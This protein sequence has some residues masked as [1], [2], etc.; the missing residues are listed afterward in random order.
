MCLFQKDTEYFEY[1]IDAFGVYPA[2]SIGCKQ[3]HSITKNFT[4]M[5]GLLIVAIGK[6]I[7]YTQYIHNNSSTEC[8][9]ETTSQ[10]EEIDKISRL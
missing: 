8:I 3:Y 7:T 5:Q 6:K 9:V 2:P 4:E 10:M 1:R